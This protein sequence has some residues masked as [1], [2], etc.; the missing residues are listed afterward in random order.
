MSEER[1]EQEE[2]KD[3]TEDETEAHKFRSKM[4]NEEPSAEDESD[5]VE[6]HARRAQHRSA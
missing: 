2:S 5:D 3:T 1:L 4:A 6:A